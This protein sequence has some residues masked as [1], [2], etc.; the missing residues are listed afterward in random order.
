MSNPIQQLRD[1]IER[2]GKQ[3]D[4]APLFELMRE[5]SCMELIL[6][7]DYEVRDASGKLMY[8]IKKKALNPFQLNVLCDE[9]QDAW[10]RDDKKMGG[11]GGMPGMG[12][13]RK[14]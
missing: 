6:G 13:G 11:K 7:V 8:T 10:K 4:I 5:T 9:L 1:R 14:K 3:S 2:G 12:R